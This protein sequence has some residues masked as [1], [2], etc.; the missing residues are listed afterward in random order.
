MPPKRVIWNIAVFMRSVPGTGLLILLNN[1]YFCA[2]YMRP[3][4][5]AAKMEMMGCNETKKQVKRNK[6]IR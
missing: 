5:Q 2:Q 1:E 6:L 3:I 4:P